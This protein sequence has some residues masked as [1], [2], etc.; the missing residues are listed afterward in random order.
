[1]PRVIPRSLLL[2]IVSLSLW[3]ETSA[4]LCHRVTST[5]KGREQ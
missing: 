2:V 5:S 4:R 1:M 3:R